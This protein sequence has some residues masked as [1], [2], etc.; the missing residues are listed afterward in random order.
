VNKFFFIRNLLRDKMNTQSKQANTLEWYA[1]KP[2]TVRSHHGRDMG[3]VN[4]RYEQLNTKKSK[5]NLDVIFE[6]ADERRELVRPRKRSLLYMGWNEYHTLSTSSCF[7]FFSHFIT[8]NPTPT[9]HAITPNSRNKSCSNGVIVKHQ[10]YFSLHLL[11]Q[12][13]NDR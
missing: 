1:G 12:Q 4:R 7:P 6:P 10:R 8:G 13:V 2:R 9:S 11:P 3:G 5:N